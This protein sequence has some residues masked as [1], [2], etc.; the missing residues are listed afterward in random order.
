VQRWVEVEERPGVVVRL[1][2]A[3]R[4]VDERAVAGA[5]AGRVPADLADLVVPRHEPHA[6][7]RAVHGRVGAEPLEQVE[8]VV[9]KVEAGLLDV[10]RPER[11]FHVR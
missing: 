2:G 3:Q 10:E 4:V 6:V 1:Q 9:T 7:G 11:C 5:E 8:V